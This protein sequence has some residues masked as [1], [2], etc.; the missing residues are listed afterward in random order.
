MGKSLTTVHELRRRWKPTKERLSAGA[1][2]GHPTAVRLH[3]A[4]SWLERCEK[5][6]EGEDADLVLICL[7]IGFNGLHGQWDELR[8]AQGEW[9][10]MTTL[11]QRQRDQYLTN[12]LETTEVA[13]DPRYRE[14]SRQRPSAF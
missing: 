5:A 8:C 14:S 2:S 10:R 12:G 11:G 4:F 13:D 7:W 3:R 9:R 6:S 1:D